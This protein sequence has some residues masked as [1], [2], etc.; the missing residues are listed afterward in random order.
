MAEEGNQEADAERVQNEHYAALE[1]RYLQE[2]DKRVRRQPHPEENAAGTANTTKDFLN[3]PAVSLTAIRA[4]LVEDVG[5]LIVGGGFAGLLAA[6]ALRTVG[7]D[8]F[9]VV[10]TAADFGGVWYWNRYPGV[11]CDVES[12]IYMPLL[13]ETGYMPSEKYAGGHDIRAHFQ[14]IARHFDLYGKARFETQ[15]TRIEWQQDDG[16]W[17]VTTNRDDAITARFI[18]L[19]SGVLSS[20]RLP[21][22][23]GIETFKGEIFHTS[24]W[25]YEYTGGNYSGDLTGLRDKRVAIIGTGATAIQVVP[26]LA[27]WAKELHVVQRTP[28]IVARRDNRPTDP[29]WARTL[30]P[31][32]Q[33]LR[34]Q[35]FEGVLAGL[36]GDPDL[37][38]DAWSDI[39]GPVTFPEGQENP[40]VRKTAARKFDFEKLEK[41][42]ARIDSIVQ[43]PATA[44]SLKPYYFR[45]CKRPSFHDQYLQSFNLPNV[46]LLDT[47]GA[48]LDRVTQTGIVFEGTETEIDCLICATGF[49]VGAF[50]QKSGGLSLIGRG[51]MSIDVRWSGGVRSLHGMYTHGFPNLFFVGNPFQSKV[52]NNYSY[53]LGEQARH[54]AKVVRRL[55]DEGLTMEVSREAENTWAEVIETKR[56][57]DQEYLRACTPSYFNEYSDESSIL[58]QFYG[59]SPFEYIDL[60]AEWLRG[61]ISRDF[62]P[63]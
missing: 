12:Y 35:N 45:F 23:D 60:L 18:I 20:P 49:E 11:A 25:N 17:H 41:I 48:G 50:S 36:V 30:L 14:R 47:R 3:D 10:D 13:E 57:V 61:D 40:D 33:K 62:E 7:I 15:V 2:R 38:G 1:R 29:D 43:D 52:V 42:R 63:A 39:W 53:M 51:G 44:E 26:H 32:W 24:R 31:G 55:L 54:V 46:K 59:G 34:M 8:D 16:R 9:C 28:A 22:I 56:T 37:V 5:V 4:P 21:A 27:Q 19:G 58:N 6:V